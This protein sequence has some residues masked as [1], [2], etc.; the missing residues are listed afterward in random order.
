MRKFIALC[1]E[2]P[3]CEY[4]RGEFAISGL[5]DFESSFS[6]K[7][8]PASLLSIPHVAVLGDV[9]IVYLSSNIVCILINFNI[10]IILF[11][12]YK[13]PDKVTQ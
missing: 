5:L 7:P 11:F 12:Y 3:L 9:F 10:S 8:T 13:S 1:T 4:S 6:E 2:E